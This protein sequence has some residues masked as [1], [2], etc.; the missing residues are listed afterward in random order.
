MRP[1]GAAIIALLML[2]AGGL[3]AWGA[4]KFYFGAYRSRPSP[5]Y[6][7]PAAV[8][9]SA[10]RVPA[11][12]ND[13][14][15]ALDDAARQT[16][17]GNI[18]GAEVQVDG[19]VADME[20][21]RVR[22]R[23]VPGDF[24]DKASSAL[25]EILKA[26][27]G[28]AT[29]AEESEIGKSA[30]I[31]AGDSPQTPGAEP[32]DAAGRLLQ[33]VAQARIELA[34]MRSWQE[35]VPSGSELALDVEEGADRSAAQSAAVAGPN[36]AADLPSTSPVTAGGRLKLPRG[37]AEI[38]APRELARNTLLNPASLHA[39]FLDA[40]LMP[41][42]SEILLPPERRQFSDNV[43]IEDVTIAGAS[44]TLDGIHWRNVTF[45]GT[46]LRYEDGSLDLQ[47]VRFIRCTFG[48]PSDQR[49][50]AIADMIARGG[51]SL[52]IQ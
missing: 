14:L 38:D 21:A 18:G 40:S 6:A 36:G 22:S 12:E 35:P 30:T 46:R 16:K 26:R 44:Q 19:A 48:F 39:S 11:W 32:P 2:G 52:T 3:M 5:M 50:A 20:V 28:A 29:T 15:S 33:H 7:A 47:N 25:D 17:V 31:N 45:I 4:A 41:D 24:F 43:R 13:V 1:Y 49:S 23:D 37:H 10:P 8:A 27:P 51:T 34:A 42:T 9:N